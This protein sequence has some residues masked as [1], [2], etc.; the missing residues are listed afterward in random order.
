MA[1]TRY[2]RALV[3]SLMIGIAVGLFAAAPAEEMATTGPVTL[4]IYMEKPGFAWD[5]TW[6]VDPVSKSWIE[7]SGAALEWIISPD[8]SDTTLNLIIA[9][10][11]FPDLLFTSIKPQITDL[12]KRDMLW[13]YDD[14]AVEFN[15][16]DFLMRDLGKNMIVHLRMR[17]EAMKVYL[18]PTRFLHEQYWYD[19]GITKAV[20][21]VTVLKNIY[22]EV[23]S[24]T[25]KNSDDYINL[26]RTVK[27]KHPD[28]IAA[29][30]NRG[31]D[32][33]L[34]ESLVPIAGLAEQYYKVGG[35]YVYYWQ[36]PNFVKLLQ[37]ANTLTREGLVDPSEYTMQAGQ[38]N[39]R[40]FSG[41]IFSEIMQDADNIDWFSGEI[42][43]QY[44]D[45]QTI[46]LPHF[47]IDPATMKYEHDVWN[48]GTSSRGTAI[49]KSTKYPEQAFD[50][51][52]YYYS[53]QG[54]AEL[55]HGILGHGYFLEDG[56]VVPNPDFVGMEE[57]QYNREV[58]GSYWIMVMNDPVGK[59][60]PLRI[61]K[62]QQEALA[63]ANKT[64][65]DFAVKRAVPPFP[66]DSE[67]LKIHA[68]IKDYFDAEVMSV[69]SADPKD[70][71]PMYNAMLKKM[72][73]MGLEKLNAFWTKAITEFETK[74]LKYSAG[75]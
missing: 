51:V 12:A 66:A 16:P 19:P 67:E 30:S 56:V 27:K 14:L 47:T 62:Y 8:N 7:K 37:V 26:L 42:Q 34:V 54:I 40:S 35:R 6:G 1:T 61:S 69:I 74:R 21:G 38:K 24:P 71:V 33:R 64:Y 36:H 53:A 3:L 20:N 52:K 28:M 9:S 73:S 17:F 45:W 31:N 44:P 18:A 49:V 11:D 2:R 63:L 50:W 57:E 29:Q 75:L 65:K 13:A 23:G 70:V 32:F 15:D 5:K 48:G 39:A 25:I 72:E 43:K 68:L 60:A 46:M 58:N 22:E 4:S 59:P 55:K 10:G 41:K